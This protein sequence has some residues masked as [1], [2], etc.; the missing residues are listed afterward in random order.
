VVVPLAAARPPI[1]S[2]GTF[3][4]DRDLRIRD[5]GRDIL[6][7]AEQLAERAA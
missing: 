3:L 5:E 1:R 2:T 4:I 6:A 7:C